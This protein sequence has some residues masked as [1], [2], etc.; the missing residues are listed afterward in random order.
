MPGWGH[1]GIQV[2]ITASHSNNTRTGRHTDCLAGLT[3]EPTV[4]PPTHRPRRPT[5]L[6]PPQTRTHLARCCWLPCC[7]A[8]RPHPPVP[9]APLV[10]AA[11]QEGLRHT[12]AHTHGS[13]RQRVNSRHASGGGVRLPAPAVPATPLLSHPGSPTNVF[14]H[15]SAPPNK[16]RLSN[17]RKEERPP[18][19]H[20][21]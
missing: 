16:A 15:T 20:R 4:D 12:Q 13:A 7:P 14:V 6:A 19:T 8:H 18:H 17:G 3:L 5:D 10:G 2:S 1:Q 11:A 9:A 21:H